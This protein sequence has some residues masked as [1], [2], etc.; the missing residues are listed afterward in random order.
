MEASFSYREDSGW[1]SALASDFPNSCKNCRLSSLASESLFIQIKNTLGCVGFHRNSSFFA[2]HWVDSYVRC[3]RDR[4]K[5][6]C[7][8]R[9]TYR[10]RCFIWYRLLYHEFW[11]FVRWIGRVCFWYRGWGWTWRVIMDGEGCFRE[12]FGNV[13]RVVLGVWFYGLCSGLEEGYVDFH[14]IGE[15]VLVCY[16]LILRWWL[17]LC[18]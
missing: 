10:Y 16:F 7:F 15:E 8:L 2:S 4:W 3:R 13:W 11:L 9:P 17:W 18:F 14:F 6:G 1:V 5:L 12:G